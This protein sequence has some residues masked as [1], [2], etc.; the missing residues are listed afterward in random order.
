MLGADPVHSF[1]KGP[2]E[3]A[4]SW[5]KLSLNSNLHCFCG[6]CLRSCCVR[7]DYA[8]A[9][10]C[11]R[12]CN[13]AAFDHTSDLMWWMVHTCLFLFKNKSRGI[14]K[15]KPTRTKKKTVR[16]STKICKMET[17]RMGGVWGWQ[18]KTWDHLDPLYLPAQLCDTS[19]LI[20]ADYL[21]AVCSVELR[22]QTCQ[23]QAEPG[24]RHRRNQGLKL[25]FSHW[26]GFS[27]SHSLDG[28]LDI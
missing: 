18:R 16:I 11:L 14:K 5:W 7:L 19:F 2:C 15:Y 21:S 24:K 13:W 20:S 9:S 3:L 12:I 25:K 26:V 8:F 4:L 10:L 28:F 23:V 22:I 17:R 27:Q 6:C 1:S